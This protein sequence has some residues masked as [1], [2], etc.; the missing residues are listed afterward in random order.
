MI[1]WLQRIFDRHKY[2]VVILFGL[3]IISFVFVVNE[4]GGFSGRDPRYG[5]QKYFGVDL[6]SAKQVVQLQRDVLLSLMLEGVDPANVPHHM[7]DQVWEAQR[8]P[9]LYIAN[10]L[11]LPG[12]DARTF[13]QYL[14]RFPV[15]RGEDGS[16]SRS[17][18]TAFIDKVD[19]NP[20]F[21]QEQLSRV[22]VEQYLIEQAERLVFGGQYIPEFHRTKFIEQHFTAWDVK[23]GVL[24]FAGFEPEIAISEQDLDAF[25]RSNAT[26]YETPEKVEGYV[27]SFKADSFQVEGEVSDSVL[28]SH[29]ERNLPRFIP[30]VAEGEKVEEPSFESV[31]EKVLEDYLQRSRMRRISEAAGDFVSYLYEAGSLPEIEELNTQVAAHNGAIHKLAPYARGEQPEGAE[32]SAELLARLFQ[33]SGRFYTDPFQNDGNYYI[34]LREKLIPHELPP[35]ADVREKVEEDYRN[36]ERRR[37]FREKGNELVS[38]LRDKVKEGSAFDEAAKGLAFDVEDFKGVSLLERAEGFPEEAALDRELVRMNDGDISSF[39]FGLQSG[40]VIYVASKE[41]KPTDESSI[42]SQMLNRQF[43]YF[44]SQFLPSHVFRSYIQ[45]NMVINR[46]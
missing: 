32:L 38:Q 10:E 13:N 39:I 6:S 2:V 4:S 7:I 28:R 25:Y 45:E 22:L 42:T 35:L 11:K 8:V 31:R 19:S 20:Q 46:L 5:E 17:A 23:L 40:Y 15:F 34:L 1:T 43:E 16:F 37:L 26:R 9:F 14:A 18:F 27:V 3:V 33:T 44:Y 41:V 24:D 30:A 21:S 12:P 29:F 36:M